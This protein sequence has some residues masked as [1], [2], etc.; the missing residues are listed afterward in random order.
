V[1]LAIKIDKDRCTGC[2][3]CVILC[4]QAAISIR[5]AKAE[6]DNR[7]CINCGICQQECLEKAIVVL[8]GKDLGG[9]GY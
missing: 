3:A 1:G 4:P 6:V 8:P 5:E 7:L 9:G 2:Y